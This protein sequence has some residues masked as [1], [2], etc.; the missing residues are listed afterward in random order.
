[1]AIEK[2]ESI[3]MLHSACVAATDAVDSLSHA[4]NCA[5]EAGSPLSHEARRLAGLAMSLAEELNIERKGL[6]ASVPTGGW[7]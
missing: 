4:R 2:G 3:S 7:S 1:M 5:E 6:E